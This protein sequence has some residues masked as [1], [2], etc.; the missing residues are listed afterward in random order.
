MKFLVIVLL[1]AVAATAQDWQIV[2]FVVEGDS[3]IR[4][5]Y[6]KEYLHPDSMYLGVQ[7]KTM[8]VR[9]RCRNLRAVDTTFR[10]IVTV[11]ASEYEE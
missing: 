3:V 6:R 10:R 4:V 9:Y 7:R 8:V 2:S 5:K 1:L 11:P